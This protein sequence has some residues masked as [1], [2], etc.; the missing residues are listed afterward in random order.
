MAGFV[1]AI[2]KGFTGGDVFDQRAKG[3]HQDFIAEMNRM[4]E[5]EQ[6]L[7]KNSSMDMRYNFRLQQHR[8]SEHG[9]RI[10]RRYLTDEK[11]H[12][13]VSVLM[14]KDKR[15]VTRIPATVCHF[16]KTFL[17]DR[18]TVRKEKTG[19]TVYSYVVFANEQ[20]P[21]DTYCCP[22]CGDINTIMQLLEQ[23]C[24]SCRTKYILPDL[25]PRITNFYTMREK[26]Y[27]RTSP[28]PFILLGIAFALSVFFFTF[29]KTLEM[30]IQLLLSLLATVFC[31][32]VIG[33]L[34]YPIGILSLLLLDAIVSGPQLYAFNKTR[35]KLPLFMQK[36]DPFFSV[37]FFVGK[38]NNLLKTLVFTDDYSNCSV[39]EKN[40]DNPC[41]DIVDVE[42]Q[43]V[44]GL[45][46]TSCDDQYVYI[47]IDVYARTAFMKNRRLKQKDELFRMKLCR[48][49]SVQ[50][51]CNASVHNIQCHAC[52]ASFN[53]VREKNCPY[54]RSA[55]NLRDYDWV[56]TAFERKGH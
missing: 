31:G 47:D 29:A 56:V 6:Y 26:S 9:I 2:R 23:G 49:V 30:D 20:N 22:N 21:D 51:D 52:G 32:V 5:D 34:L 16:E 53:A 17:S 13:G 18:K 33:F 10:R 36:Y 1:E 15:Y 7:P 24:R 43:G 12:T 3:L 8:A 48:S 27:V 54:C 40:G 39:Y 4:A 25:Y 45:N 50:D 35:K 41:K 37:D 11:S 28:F 46:S 42:Y 44:I 14:G 19:G 55:Y 38:V